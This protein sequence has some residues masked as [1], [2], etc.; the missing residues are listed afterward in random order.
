MSIKLQI[1]S[2]RIER[3]RELKKTAF[4]TTGF[5]TATLLQINIKMWI[6]SKHMAEKKGVYRILV[7]KP[8]GK[9]PVG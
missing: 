2:C 6:K 9:R 8:E 4:C 1:T 3:K 5:V 7:R